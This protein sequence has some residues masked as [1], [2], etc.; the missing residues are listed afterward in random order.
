MHPMNPDHP[1]YAQ[2]RDAGRAGSVENR[3]GAS[4]IAR[5]D[6]LACS[7]TYEDRDGE[8]VCGAP[9]IYDVRRFDGE[10]VTI[11]L[12]ERD[13]RNYTAAPAFVVARVS[14]SSCDA[15]AKTY[16]LDS[17]GRCDECRP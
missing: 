11:R 7:Y 17:S 3:V 1:Q 13:V 16:E 12:C 8:R 15:D 9:A 2:L 10:G 6:P 14:C 4:P 5:T